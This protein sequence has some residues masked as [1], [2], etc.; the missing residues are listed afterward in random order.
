VQATLPLL[1]AIQAKQSIRKGDCAYL[2]Y[3]TTKLEG[4]LKLENVSVVCDYPDVFSKVYSGLP[5]D[6]KIEFTID[7]VSGTQPIHKAPYR[8]A[9]AELKELKEQL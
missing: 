5:P 8:M 4:E 2:A 3:V 7:L 6:Q 9:P 1:S